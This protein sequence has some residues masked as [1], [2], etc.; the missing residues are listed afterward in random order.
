[1]TESKRSKPFLNDC[2]KKTCILD[3]NL[4]FQGADYY[5]VSLAVSDLILGV[6]LIPFSLTSFFMEQWI[7]HPQICQ[8]WAYMWFLLWLIKV[9][10]F[11]LLS[12]DRRLYVTDKKYSYYTN[13][14][15]CRYVIDCN[16][17]IL[18]NYFENS[19]Y[20]GLDVFV[21]FLQFG[22]GLYFSA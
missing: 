17:V 20:L 4:N 11:M 3:E 9:F 14:T 2:M 15:K 1:M 5:I 19:F 16:I 13:H 21:K 22:C 10:T 7:F 12:T 18:H 8:F 6:L